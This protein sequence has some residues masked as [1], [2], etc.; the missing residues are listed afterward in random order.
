MVQPVRFERFALHFYG[1]NLVVA[2]PAMFAEAGLLLQADI[3][4]VAGLKEQNAEIG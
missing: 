4:R 2:H 3:F 1:Q